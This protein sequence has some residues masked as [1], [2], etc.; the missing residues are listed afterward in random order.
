MTS[1]IRSQLALPKSVSTTSN[2][3]IVIISNATCSI[4]LETAR[5]LILRG[6]LVS[7]RACDMKKL[8]SLF[9]DET[10][11]IHYARF[12]AKDERT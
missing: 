8:K 5:A 9:R 2:N 11:R 10:E 4:S 7:L 12:N 1:K 6:H 3:C